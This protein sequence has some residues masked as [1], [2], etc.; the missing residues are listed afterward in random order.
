MARDQG[1]IGKYCAQ[2]QNF[3]QQARSAMAL[4]IGDVY[5][6]DLLGGSDGNTGESFASPFLTINHAYNRVGSDS[7][8][9]IR[10]RGF[11]ESAATG[12][13]ATCDIGYTHLIGHAG[14]M[15]PYF[16]EKGSLSRTGAG[17]APYLLVSAEFVEVAGF[18]IHAHQ[19]SG[20]ESGNV[21]KSSM[22]IGTA[23]S[24][25]G[26]KA[27]VHNMHFPDWNHAETETGLSVHG[28]HYFVLDGIT[29]D[30]IY[31]NIE[32]GIRI[33]GS[34]G[35]NSANAVIRNIWCKGG[36]GGS[37]T[38]GIKMGGGMSLQSSQFTHILHN[39]GTNMFDLG[40][41]GA[42]YN[43]WDWLRGDMTEANAFTGGTDPT[44]RA[45]LWTNNKGIVGPNT[46]FRDAAYTDAT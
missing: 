4:P 35:S 2:G 17:D 29:I 42:A 8:D 38:T 25:G 46:Y 34:S 37:L 3:N 20:T 21:S 36:A 44:N 39:R 27:F 28:S 11:N 18:T 16:P 40:G 41:N 6:V 5:Y 22:N 23:A 43:S 12:V 9:Y 13:V 1:W 7:N 10:V 19:S 14:L 45:D 33:D 32:T 31:G 26:N 30:S 24:G 15:N